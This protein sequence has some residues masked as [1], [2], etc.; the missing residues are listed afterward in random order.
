MRKLLFTLLAFVCSLTLV[1]AQG[2]V[3]VPTVSLPKYP[4]V[5]AAVQVK[6][7][8]K[9]VGTAAVTSLT[10][11][12]AI[13]NSDPVSGNITIAIAAGA[14]V[15]FTHPVVWTPNAAVVNS[16]KVWATNINTVGGANAAAT[17]GEV[18]TSVTSASQLAEK[19]VLIEYFSGEWCGWCPDGAIAIKQVKDAFGDKVMASTI[20]QGDFMQNADGTS[21]ISAFAISGYPSGM[22]D[23]KSGGGSEIMNR[24]QFYGAVSAQLTATPQLPIGID[25]EQT[26]NCNTRQVTVKATANFYAPFSESMRIMFFVQEDE[27]TGVAQ[28][29]FLNNTVGHPYYQ[30]GDPI[31]GYKHKDVFRGAPGTIF[32][33]PIVGTIKDGSKFSQTFT[34]T[35]PSGGDLSKTYLIAAVV[36]NGTAQGQREIYNIRRA[37]IETTRPMLSFMND[38][39]SG[40]SV[41]TNVPFGSVACPNTPTITVTSSNQAVIPNASIVM[42]GSGENRNLAIN[43]G[44]AV[45]STNITITS[46][47]GAFVTTRTFAFVVSAA[48]TI[49]V[50]TNKITDEDVALPINF[51]IG[52][53]VTSLDNLI[54]TATSSNTNVVT[55]TGIAITGTGA[56]RTLTLTPIA[57]QFG[58]TNITLTVKDGSN[59]TS[60]AMFALQVNSINDLPTIT[61]IADRLIG[62]SHT[63]TL[64]FGIGDAETSVTGLVVAV[65]SN[66]QTAVPNANLV[67]SGS[68][69]ARVLTI[70]SANVSTGTAKITISVTDANGGVGTRDFI[71]TVDEINA[72]ENAFVDRNVKV[73][74]NPSTRFL[75]IETGALA[76]KNLQFTISNLNGKQIQVLTPTLE[77][78]KVQLDLQTLK[79]GI[80]LLE[81]SNEKGKAIR[82]IVKE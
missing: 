6:G 58:T 41:V 31:P 54:L 35:V 8:L 52:D 15:S 53:D 73:Y 14:T 61:A 23:R 7:Q 70:T 37:V 11:H 25:I 1:L 19:K 69:N 62:K 28:R 26:Y 77:S 39:G 76:T 44:T 74:P 42:T 56:N 13:N 29:N 81:I 40:V 2:N 67:L 22:V 20:H 49:S 51:T 71:L 10:L 18:T 16:V 64:T 9:N 82:K 24:G 79:A 12:Y 46:T 78:D 72:A 47:S 45:G 21:L 27:V 48:P 60:Q 63:I 66:N 55:A 65:A 75:Q 36:K 17:N 59:L 68:A 33:Q 80:Y 3:Q 5:G 43:A 32:G 4:L 34:Y 57:N 30:L 38:N 50:I